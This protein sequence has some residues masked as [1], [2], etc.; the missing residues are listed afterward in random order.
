MYILYNYNTVA[1]LINCLLQLTNTVIYVNIDKI[2][3]TRSC[4]F[5]G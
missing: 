5:E 3:C 2:G 1:A 4:I